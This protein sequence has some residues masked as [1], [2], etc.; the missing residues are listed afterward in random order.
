MSRPRVPAQQRLDPVPPKQPS[1]QQMYAPDWDN[2]N[3]RLRESWAETY[4]DEKNGDIRVKPKEVQRGNPGIVK[5][6]L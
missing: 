1:E 4:Y 6:G 2:P 3:R 5:R